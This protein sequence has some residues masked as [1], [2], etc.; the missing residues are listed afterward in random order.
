MLSPAQRSARALHGAS[1]CVFAIAV[2]CIASTASG[3]TWKAGADDNEGLPTLS[4]G[5]TVALSSAYVFWGKNWVFA[6]EQTDFKVTAPF[7]YS[8]SGK[9]ATLNFDVV[10][11]A[12]KR[13]D[14]QLTWDF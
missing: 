2:L 6:C 10:G 3:A 13:S 1:L 14:T 9:N 12:K 8:F 5:G 11:H 7:D 4:K